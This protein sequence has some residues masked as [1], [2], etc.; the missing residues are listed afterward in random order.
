M[1]LLCVDDNFTD[2]DARLLF[3]VRL[4]QAGAIRNEDEK[5]LRERVKAMLAKAGFEL[6]FAVD[7][8]DALTRYRRNGPY[9]LVLTDLV[10]PGLDGA[11]LVRT[12]RHENPTQAIAVLTAAPKLSD[13][14]R[15]IFTMFDI[16]VASKFIDEELLR[17]FLD[18]T[19]SGNRQLDIGIWKLQ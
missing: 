5:A 6:E 19:V 9:D 15:E 13:S 14:E 2:E 10:H 12:I 3:S 7:G 17:P 1:K 8:D 16:P 11:E 18:H 4:M